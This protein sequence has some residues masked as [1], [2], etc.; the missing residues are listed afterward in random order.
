MVQSQRKSYSLQDSWTQLHSQY[1]L[2]CEP[3]VT[4]L[5][6]NACYVLSFRMGRI[7]LPVADGLAYATLQEDVAVTYSQVLARSHPC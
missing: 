3:P 4:Y 1:I 7:M 5:L 2:H 6:G